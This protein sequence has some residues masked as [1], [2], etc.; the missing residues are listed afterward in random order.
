MR[1]MLG[2]LTS[3]LAGKNFD[4]RFPVAHYW[5][6]KLNRLFAKNVDLT[7][8]LPLNTILNYNPKQAGISYYLYNFGEY[9]PYATNVFLN[10]IK[11]GDTVIDIGANIGYY[12]VLGA[13]KVGAK[14]KVLAIEP[15][16]TNLSYLKR[17]LSQNNI[18]NTQIF[19]GA[20]SRETGTLPL[21]LS[22]TSAGEH[23]LVV[24]TDK[25]ISVPVETLDHLVGA[26]KLKPT[27]IKIDVEGAEM[28]VLAGASKTLSSLRPTIIFEYS[29]RPT[30]ST[31]SL[32][33]LQKHKYQL[34]LLDE[35]T[36]TT[37]SVDENKISE[38]LAERTYINLLADPE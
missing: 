23:S 6:L 4:K 1:A 25:A 2:I 27:L 20:V 38:L 24:K 14:G 13:T 30:K 36:K 5:F 7:I 35:K 18:Q 16:P 37:T 31:Y 28:D 10:L 29:L 9:E 26:Y 21:Y 8:S 19:A 33:D 3:L 12:T 17:N 32:K 11:P 15:E 22:S 34:F